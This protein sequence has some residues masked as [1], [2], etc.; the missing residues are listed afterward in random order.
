VRNPMWPCACCDAA[1]THRDE[2]GDARCEQHRLSQDI[3]TMDAE[4][5]RQLVRNLQAALAAKEEA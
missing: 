4:R 3:D 1:A 2:Y 5:L